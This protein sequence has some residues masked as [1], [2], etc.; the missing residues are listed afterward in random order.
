MNNA[1]E[2]KMLS[3]FV[4]RIDFS[5]LAQSAIF[6]IS[7]PSPDIYLV[8]KVSNTQKSSNRLEIAIQRFKTLYMLLWSN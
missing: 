1:K 6:S 7:N 8:V 4:K 3:N 5:T 2:K